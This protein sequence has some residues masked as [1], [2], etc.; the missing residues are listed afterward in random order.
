[1]AAQVVP[2]PID[3]WRTS[4]HRAP[5]WFCCQWCPVMC[6][7]QTLADAHAELEA[8][9]IEQHASRVGGRQ[10]QA[11]PSPSYRDLPPSA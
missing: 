9:V 5:V 7:G 4:I 3:R 8:H 2:F 6:G 10:P 11:P 1:M